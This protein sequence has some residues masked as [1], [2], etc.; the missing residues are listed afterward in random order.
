MKKISFLFCAVLLFA[1][2][3][4]ASAGIAETDGYKRVRVAECFNTPAA[5]LLLMKLDAGFIG[6]GNPPPAWRTLASETAEDRELLDDAAV[7]GAHDMVITGDGEYADKLESRGLIRK[8]APLW[9][10]RLILVGP[11]GSA[12]A[13][14]GMEASDIMKKVVS[15]NLLF[16]S[17][18]TDDWARG[19]E[20]ALWKKAGVETLDEYGGYVETSR[21]SLSA[22]MQAG[23]EG[24]FMLTREGPYAQYAD[25]ERFEPA[26]VKIAATEYFCTAY[27]CPVSN[28]GFRKFRAEGAEKF[29]EWLLS[30]DG[31]R[32]I[33]EF[34]IGGLNPFIPVK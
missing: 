32:E 5:Q 10:E 2:V 29:L 11:A 16:F 26:L 12:P 28:S 30:P 9:S 19:A 1:R 7:V 20:E 21:D 22:L 25:A 3:G 23:D 17:R 4:A 15:Q 31:G 18:I 14:I 33:S 24:A 27:A 8:K 6:A 13:F 34:S